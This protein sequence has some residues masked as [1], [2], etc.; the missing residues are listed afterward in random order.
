MR[1][2]VTLSFVLIMIDKILPHG[3]N[4]R[5]RCQERGQHG[6]AGALL[7]NDHERFD[8]VTRLV[9]LGGGLL[10]VIRNDIQPGTILETKNINSTN[11]REL[12]N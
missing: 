9:V 2:V 6:G 5:V 10:E 3:D 4:F 12:F 7:G 11:C 1:D 8:L